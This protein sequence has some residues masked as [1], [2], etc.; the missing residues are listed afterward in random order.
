ATWSGGTNAL[1]A[2]FKV[3]PDGSGYAILRS[4]GSGPGDGANPGSGII[5]GSD[6]FLYGTTQNGGSNSFGTVF[7]LQKDGTSYTVLHTF[8]GDGDGENPP[9]AVLEASDGALYGVTYYGG[10][11]GAGAMYR[12]NKDGSAYAIVHSFG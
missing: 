5:Q 3:D 11:N 8:G 4:F 12:L 1:G 6:G 7:K 10:A 2:V 9:D